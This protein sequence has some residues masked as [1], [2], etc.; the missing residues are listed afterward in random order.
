MRIANKITIAFSI[1][2]LLLPGIAGFIFYEFSRNELKKSI[3]AH[4]DTAVSSKTKHIETFLKMQKNSISQLVE[5][6]V[7]RDLLLTKKENPRYPDKLNLV[8]KRFSSTEKISPHTYEI[9]L[10]NANGKIVACSNKNGIC[11]DKDHD[12]YFL[13]VKK[14]GK[15]YI[16]DA[17]YSETTGQE[18]MAISVPVI[19]KKTGKLLGVVVAR[20]VMNELNEIL[21]DRTGLGKTGCIY[22]VNRNGLMI[23]PSRFLK[24][25]F[26]KLK[27][28]TAITRKHFENIKKFGAGYYLY[29]PMLYRDYRGVKVLGV[30]KHLPELQWILLAEIDEKEAFAPLAKMKFLFIII[31][32]FIP[33]SVFLVSNFISFFITRPLHRLHQG[34]EIVGTGNLDYKVGTEAKDEVGQLSREFDRMTEHLKKTTVSIGNLSQEIVER[35][36]AEEK[37]RKNEE[38]YKTLVENLPQKIFLKD[39]NSIYVSCN[40]NYAQD[41]KIKSDE[42]VGKTDNDFHPKELAEKYRFDDKKL[43][44]SG[45]MDEIQERYIQDGQ[46][47]FVQ[48]IKIPV[49]NANGEVI[50]ILGIFWDITE[51]KRAEE[52]A[53]KAKEQAEEYLNIAKVMITAVDANEKITMINRKGCE[54]LGYKERELIG[55]NWFDLLVP[56]RIREDVRG[57]FNRLMAGKVKSVKYYENPLLTKKGEE[58]IFLF[59]NSILKDSKGKINGAL[60]SAEDITERKKAEKKIKYISFHDILTGLYNRNFFEEEMSRLNTH[61]QYPVSI[62]VADINGLKFVNDTFGHPQGDELLKDVGGILRSISRKEDIVSRIGGDEFTVVLPQ[63]DENIARTF[64]DR[65][66][67]ECKEYNRQSI[68]KSKLS[69]ALGCATQSGQYKNMNEVLKEADKSMYAE[70]MRMEKIS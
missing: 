12:A 43:M 55:K 33:L 65:V 59:H 51:K 20:I 52:E 19:A 28:D 44:E 25:T 56:K 62:I 26:L 23:T 3:Y 64:C 58:R 2:G 46:E 41:L 47:K 37:L 66:R 42:I 70:K 1:V 54:D 38:K 8:M 34:M 21:T 57:V 16:K 4:L 31:L 63:S 6:V 22:I 13:G 9:F 10:L 11:L 68:H 5:S 48:T 27:V 7:V 30:H 35:K 39:R 18:V 40:N 49:K 24:D 69:I 50:G 61:R 29:K 60:F 17:Y 67:N 15:L 53:K 45:K 32:I 14:S 36:R